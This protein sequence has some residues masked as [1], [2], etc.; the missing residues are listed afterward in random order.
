[1]LVESIGARLAEVGRL[2]ALGRVERT[3]DDD[4]ASRSGNSAQR[5]RA[6]HDAF[7]VPG[8]LA[9]AVSGLDGSPV[10]LV[11]DL[12]DTGWTITVAA[13]L[14]REAGASGVLPLALALS[15]SS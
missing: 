8:P 2:P 6:V 15:S 11:D 14:L 9:A 13:G 4:G 10:L 3:R 1:V 12:V 5:V 7:A